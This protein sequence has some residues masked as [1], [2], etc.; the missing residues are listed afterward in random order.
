MADKLT[1]HLA[2]VTFATSGFTAA[3][4]EL[5]GATYSRPSVPTT[6]LMTDEYDTFIPGDT[7][8]PG[9]SQYTYY[10]D[11]ESLPPINGPAEIIIVTYPD[12]STITRT[13][14]LTGCEEGAA[15]SSTVMMGTATVKWTGP[16]NYSGMGS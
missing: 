15:V 14:F 13:G 7:V 3:F 8:D 1:G 6:D 5:G 11:T 2:T 10:W 12:L 16:P 9:E 4:T